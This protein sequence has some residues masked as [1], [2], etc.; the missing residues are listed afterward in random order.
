VQSWPRGLEGFVP[1]SYLVA[2][3][4]GKIVGRVSIRH[5]LNDFLRAYGG[6]I[7]YGVVPSERRKGYATEILKLALLICRA[8][9]LEK[10]MIR[11]DCDNTGSMKVIEKM[12]VHSKGSQT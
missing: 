10:I 3:V 8:L 2:V 9:N 5:E 1:S 7:G 11:C 12:V 4:S 6:H